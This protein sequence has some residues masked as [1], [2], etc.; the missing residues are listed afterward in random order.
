MQHGGIGLAVILRK[1]LASNHTSSG[2]PTTPSTQVSTSAQ[3][4]T[5]ATCA[6]SARVRS[7]P[8]CAL[9]GC[10]HRH[11]GLAEGPFGKQTPKQVGN[12][13]RY[14]EGIGQGVGAKDRTP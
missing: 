7:S 11:K 8:C 13:K 9:A 2:A 10:Q 4:S 1:P 5:V 14:V 3:N 6:I 12:A